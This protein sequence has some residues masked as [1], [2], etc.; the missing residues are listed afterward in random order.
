MQ[1]LIPPY[2]IKIEEK[3]TFIEP[4]TKLQLAP[5]PPLNIAVLMIMTYRLNLSNLPHDQCSNLIDST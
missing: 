5:Q 4:I 1:K 2:M 3:S